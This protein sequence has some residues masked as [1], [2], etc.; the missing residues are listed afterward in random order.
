MKDTIISDVQNF[1]LS[2]LG[3]ITLLAS[4]ILGR[5]LECHLSLVKPGA[6]F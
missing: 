2:L 6:S 3:V 4:T 5:R 1:E